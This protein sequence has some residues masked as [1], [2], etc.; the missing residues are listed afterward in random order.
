M[1]IGKRVKFAIKSICLVFVFTSFSSDAFAKLATN[2]AVLFSGGVDAR[3]NSF[4]FYESTVRMWE[5]L[6]ET[7][8]FKPANIY[9][10]AADGLD[11]ALD[12]YNEVTKNYGN[13]DW[14]K[15]VGAGSHVL[16]ATPFNLQKTLKQLNKD[17]G[18]EA[19]FYFWAEDHGA[20]TKKDEIYLCAWGNKYIADEDFASWV[21]PFQVKNEVYVFTQC[22]GGGMVDD[23]YLTPGDGRFAAWAADWYE[24][25]WYDPKKGNGGWSSAWMDGIEMGL[26]STHDLGNYALI[27]DPYG[28]EGKKKE[29]PGF[30]GDDFFL[31]A[32]PESIMYKAD[33]AAPFSSSCY[34]NVAKNGKVYGDAYHDAE[35]NQNLIPVHFANPLGIGVL[36]S[37]VGYYPGA[38]FADHY[39]GK[40]YWEADE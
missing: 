7:L 18:Q 14:S 19:D 9:V 21:N 30:M 11:P 36:G 8:E 17:M 35:S 39:F 34:Y 12:N 38:G 5:L 2:Y 28:P 33:M 22:F 40:G 23:L 37:E 26:R 24:S 15:I 20:K 3:S 31:A 27:H 13:S 1:M 10:L 16:A 6:T 32:S 29:H 25:S 4:M